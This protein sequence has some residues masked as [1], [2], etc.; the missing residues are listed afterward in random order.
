MSGIELRARAQDVR[1]GLPVV[2]VTGRPKAIDLSIGIGSIAL[3]KPVTRDALKA[4][5]DDVFDNESIG[6][7]HLGTATGSGTS[8]QS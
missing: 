8:A 2:L 1:S 7:P 5:L 6:I 3:C 4:V